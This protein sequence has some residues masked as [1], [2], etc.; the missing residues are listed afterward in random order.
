VINQNS[1]QALIEFPVS[2]FVLAL[3]FALGAFLIGG[4][5][6]KGVLIY[7]SDQALLCA[8]EGDGLDSCKIKTTN[9]LRQLLGNSGIVT[10]ELKK[11]EEQKW[12]C[13]ITWLWNYWREGQNFRFVRLHENRELNLDSPLWHSP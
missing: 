2:L 3:C 8:A 6:I 10:V 5:V 1:G 13:E 12:K 9:R 7:Q 4:I 11:V